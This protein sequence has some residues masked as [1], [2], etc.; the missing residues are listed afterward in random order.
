MQIREFLGSY[1]MRS[2]PFFD[3]LTLRIAEE[4]NLMG[5]LPSLIVEA[6]TS[7]YGE[8]KRIRGALMELGYKISGGVDEAEIL[9]TSLAMEM[10]QAGFLVQDD[11]MDKDEVRRGLPTLH[12]RIAKEFKGEESENL[13]LGNCMA[14]N[15]GDVAFFWTGRILSESKFS[16]ENKIR[17]INELSRRVIMVGYGQMLDVANSGD[18]QI[19]EDEITKVHRYKTAEYTGALPLYMGALLAGEKDQARLDL[20]Q[21]YGLSLGWA[22]QIQD[23]IL[24]IYGEEEETG[25][26]VG[27]DLREGRNTLFLTYLRKTGSKEEIEFVEGLRGKMISEHELEK[28]REILKSTGVF[29]S[30]VQ[31]R[32]KYAKDAIST[33]EKLSADQESKDT[34]V[35]L[36]NFVVGRNS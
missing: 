13:H 30:V 4:A 34:L 11:F 29:G 5:K 35:N 14:V 20:F 36:V 22:F 12:T 7:F 8:G 6:F 21:S 17:A 25:K 23:D 2:Q 18:N 28:A 9:R 32:D 1:K 16:D 26:G 19:S 10:L 27:T 3:D 31:M 15:M 33:L 24:G